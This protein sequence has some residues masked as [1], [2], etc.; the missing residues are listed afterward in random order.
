[1][2]A[3][4]LGSY[5]MAVTLAGMPCLSRLKSMMR[6][7]RLAPPPRKRLEMRPRLLRP[8]VLGLPSTSDFSGVCLVMSSRVTT[9]MKRRD[10]V[11]GLYALIGISETS[12]LGFGPRMNTHEHE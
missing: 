5:S 11:T 3:E 12:P 1:M 7:A 6:Y 9:V 8:P 4:R 2:R 10:F